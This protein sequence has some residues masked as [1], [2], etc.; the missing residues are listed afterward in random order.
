M[1]ASEKDEERP[2]DAHSG[3]LSLS[4]TRIVGSLL[5]ESSPLGLQLELSGALGT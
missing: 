3:V 4:T 5:C 2:Y 1:A